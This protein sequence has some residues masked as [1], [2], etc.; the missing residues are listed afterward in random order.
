MDTVVVD[1]DIVSFFFRGDSRAAQ[2]QPH[3][4]GRLLLIAFMT[5]AELERWALARNWGPARRAALAAH[6]A[7]FV[8]RHST[9]ELCLM[10]ARVT[11]EARRAG[12]SIATSDAWHAATALLEDVP[13]VTHNRRD[14][15]GVSGLRMI[16]E[17]P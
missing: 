1:T 3:L 11:D 12:R 4:D 14:Y 8:I 17:A 2:Y 7:P 10:W 13:L 6:L 16:S 9:R 15:A 5:V